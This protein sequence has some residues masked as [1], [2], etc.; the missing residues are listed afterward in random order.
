[1]FRAGISI[2]LLVV[3]FIFA[4]SAIV[5]PVYSSIDTDNFRRSTGFFQDIT[6]KFIKPD[7]Y[8]V[9]ISIAA[10]AAYS[11][12]TLILVLYHFEKTQTP[13]LSFIA[14]FI[15]SLVFEPVR[16]IVPLQYV[17]NIP[18]LYLLMASRILLFSRN[19]GLLSLFVASIY[20]VGLESQ[21]QR[22]T[23]FVIAVI[24]LTIAL[25]TPVDTF[26][27][28]A[29]FEPIS[30]WKSIFQIFNAGIFL[31]TTAGFLIAGYMQ[32]SKSYIFISAGAFLVLAGRNILLTTDN[33]AGLPGIIMLGLG[34]WFMCAYLHRV[35]LWL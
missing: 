18:S 5:F 34:T 14:F 10:L 6:G 24:A 2:S 27:W 17:F 35:Y 16:L 1:M 8:A 30:G 12:V 9:H 25:G 19:F 33:W 3:I 32:K 4:V 7:F 21:R 31:L 26:S 11:L 13:E 22:N 29:N 23:T 20:A 28:S 15:I